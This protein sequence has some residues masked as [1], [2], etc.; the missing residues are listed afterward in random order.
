LVR[1]AALQ[2][3][4]RESLSALKRRGVIRKDFI[5]RLMRDYLPRH[6]AYFGE[7]IWI[8]MMLEQWAR[9]FESESLSRSRRVG[10]EAL[11]RT[12]N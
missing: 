10:T 8:L 6:P 1:H 9:R 2:E 3:L 12:S 5:D 11:L 4:A 7:M